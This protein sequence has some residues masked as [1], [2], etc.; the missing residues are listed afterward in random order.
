MESNLRDNG[1]LNEQHDIENAFDLNALYG[2]ASREDIPWS[3][4]NHWMRNKLL[5]HFPV[6]N[7]YTS[8]SH[9]QVTFIS[10]QSQQSSLSNSTQQYD[11]SAD[12]CIIM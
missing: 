9:Q 10:A 8:T 4:W 6:Q 1:I 2:C 11:T 7:I 3:Q 12:E 5:D